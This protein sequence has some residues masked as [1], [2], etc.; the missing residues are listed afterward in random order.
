LTV[1]P[2]STFP[3]LFSE[4]P[5]LS[6]CRLRQHIAVSKATFSFLSLQSLCSEIIGGVPS[7]Y[8][9]DV[10][11]LEYGFDSNAAVLLMNSVNN[12]AGFAL[13]SQDMTLSTLTLG[14]IASLYEK[15]KENMTSPESMVEL[16]AIDVQRQSTNAPGHSNLRRSSKR[17]V[18]ESSESKGENVTIIQ[19]SHFLNSSH[20][21]TESDPIVHSFSF[22]RELSLNSETSTSKS[23]MSKR[24]EDL[25]ER[26]KKWHPNRPLPHK[27]S[28][29]NP[30]CMHED[31]IVQSSANQSLPSLPIPPVG[32][33]TPI[34]NQSPSFTTASPRANESLPSIST[35]PRGLIYS[36]PKFASK[37]SA[38]V[39]RKRRQTE[40]SK[41]SSDRSF[42]LKRKEKFTESP[43]VSV[44]KSKT[45]NV[46]V[47][48]EGVYE[49]PFQFTGS[50]TTSLI[51]CGVSLSLPKSPS[52]YSFWRNISN[53]QPLYSKITVFEYL[54][55]GISVAEEAFCKY[56]P[57]IER[58]FTTKK[59]RESVT[60]GLFSSSSPPIDDPFLY[61][62]SQSIQEVILILC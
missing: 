50:D 54:N 35:S 17:G 16:R 28:P 48:E 13:L 4:S 6:T 32:Q 56:H 38:P 10:P 3:S 34:S 14:Y 22:P 55:Q 7:D 15:K 49:I 31:T 37:K 52:L 40:S 2:F 60:V 47:E 8:V 26:H 1:C 46:G 5:Y 62:A 27:R 61:F 30:D 59:T 12:L 39:Q 20:L 36:K 11:L 44:K 53:L 41:K 23:P 57:L 51:L 45:R 29:S 58:S 21:S 19:T 24:E 43:G 18:R 9:A 25:F 33:K 42:D